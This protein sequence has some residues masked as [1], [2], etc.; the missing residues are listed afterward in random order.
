MGKGRNVYR[1]LVKVC[2]TLKSGKSEEIQVFV[3]NTKM[4]EFFIFPISE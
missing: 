3:A 1:V 2:R 4:P